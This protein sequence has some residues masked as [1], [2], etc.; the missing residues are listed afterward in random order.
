M[1]W[2]P[3]ASLANDVF[4]G[5]R[6]GFELTTYNVLLPHAQPTHHLTAAK[7]HPPRSRLVRDKFENKLVD[8]NENNRPSFVSY[9]VE[10]QPS[11][12]A[13]SG[14]IPV[15]DKGAAGLVVRARVCWANGPSSRHPRACFSSSLRCLPSSNWIPDAKT[16]ALTG[17]YQ[18]SVRAVQLICHAR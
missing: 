11:N 2:F 14:S 1:R 5:T 9:A 13:T 15:A 10:Q 7:I 12:F 18:P 8:N 17:H 4:I 3:V 16:G 6:A